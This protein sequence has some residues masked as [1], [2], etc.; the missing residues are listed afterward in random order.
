MSSLNLILYVALLAG[1][2][3]GTL[4]R[5]AV[6]I[7]AVVCLFGLKQWGA[8]AH[9]WL[10]QHGAFTNIAIGCVVLAALALQTFRGECVLCRMGKS[11]WAVFA[12]YAYALL[13]LFWTPRPDL[14][15]GTVWL[16]DY[17]L[18]VTAVFLAPLTVKNL[19]GL[20]TTLIALAVTGGLLMVVMLLFG[21]WGNRGLITLS[22]SLLDRETNPLAIAGLAGCVAAAAMFAPVRNLKWLVWLPRLAVLAVCLVVVVRS[23]SRGQLIAASLAIVAMLPVAYRASRFTG[24]AAIVIAVVVLGGA[25]V[26]GVS[27]F[28][29]A[30]DARWTQSLAARDA[31]GRWHATQRL[32]SVW[33]DSG[34]GAMLLGLGNSAS[35]DPR[36][37]GFYPHNIPLEVLGE[38]GLIGAVL[39]IYVL[40]VA[41]SGLW[42]AWQAVQGRPE[43]RGVVAAV[44]AAF[45]F[46]FLISLKEGNMI[47]SCY[48]FLFAILLGRM[49]SLVRAE[50]RAR[51]TAVVEE[52]EVRMVAMH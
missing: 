10:A 2:A 3:V 27:E 30:G 40:W 47:G 18:I 8:S 24:L 6:A 5:P 28:I 20:R 38:E 23:G 19:D 44:G 16:H 35:F 52:N 14:A 29:Q 37:I 42:R 25:V 41:V 26:Y 45:T 7:A 49:P 15:F 32:I 34:A 22:V 43:A 51:R 36:I 9:P 48:F 11:Y 17:P 31:L 50:E 12:L 21:K 1:L 33:S 46:T 13:S 39:Y 4:L